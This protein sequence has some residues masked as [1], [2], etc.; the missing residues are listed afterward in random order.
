MF[1]S[2]SDLVHRRIK[3]SWTIPILYIPAIFSGYCI[4][5]LSADLFIG[6][7]SLAIF[8]YLTELFC[9]I[10]YNKGKPEDKQVTFVGAQDI[11]AAPIYTVWFG[12]GIITFL[13]ILLLV[14]M[15]VDT[16]PIKKYMAQLCID[17]DNMY[18]DYVALLPC[19]HITFM[20][21]L[22]LYLL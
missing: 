11:L 16:K 19:L 22:F 6:F 14:L 7:F 20:I 13:I 8:F 4:Y 21:V 9:D 2:K 12:A 17:K 1:Y 10:K 18:K 5:G 15:I 3:K